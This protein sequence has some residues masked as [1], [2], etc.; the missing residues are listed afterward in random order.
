VALTDLLNVLERYAGASP[1]NPPASTQQDFSAVSQ[2]APQDHLAG[3]LANA[4]RSDQTPP[5]GQM[6]SQLFNQSNA[7]QKAGIVNQLLAAAGPNV[8]SM[9]GGGLGAMLGSNANVTPE[10]AQQ[11][12]AESVQKLAEHSQQNDP[13][14][15]ERASAFY[16]QHPQVV[17]ALGAG[18][19]AMI[20][21][22]LSSRRA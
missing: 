21:S 4:F 10:Q 8:G 1:A 20:M 9:L 14:I 2:T 5:F 18:A 12:P 17:Q 11:I 16:A 3:G 7:Q 6:I 22:H 19:L 13:S 15:I